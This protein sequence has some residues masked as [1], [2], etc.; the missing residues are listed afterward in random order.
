[1]L[2]KSPRGRQP[3]RKPNAVRLILH[4]AYIDLMEFLVRR[5]DA[6]ALRLAGSKNRLFVLNEGYLTL[7]DSLVISPPNRRN[8]LHQRANVAFKYLW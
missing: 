1:M 8:Q 4:F 7:P 5:P 3:I 2:P 6:A